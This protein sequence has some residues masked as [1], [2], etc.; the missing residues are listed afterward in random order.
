MTRLNCSQC[1]TALICNVN[2]INA[3]WCNQLP[4]ILPLE[5][6]ATSCLCPQ[7]TL[8]KI[9]AYLAHIYTQPIKAQIEF[10]K[11][12]RGNENLIEGLDYTM[13][14]GYMVFSKWFFLKRGTCCKNGC[15][16]CPYS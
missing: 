1:H 14:N 15:K 11:R 2:D 6:S 4:A 5:E 12:F 16:N 3:C 10:A 7:C 9:N 13:Q 8:N